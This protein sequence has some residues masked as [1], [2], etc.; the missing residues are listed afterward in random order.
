MVIS[1]EN[2]T[3]VL[4]RIPPNV[5]SAHNSLPPIL[6]FYIDTSKDTPYNGLF[7]DNSLDFSI[8][9]VFRREVTY[10]I[11]VCNFL[12]SLAHICLASPNVWRFQWH[13]S[14][15]SNRQCHVLC[16][17]WSVIYFVHKQHHCYGCRTQ[18]MIYF[19]RRRMEWGNRELERERERKILEIK[20]SRVWV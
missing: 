15:G 13:F 2:P 8:F 14:I 7:S 4:A 9:Y 10:H 19:M 6:E 16:R 20:Y 1:Q 12:P 11:K 3:Y 17:T 5:S 18:S